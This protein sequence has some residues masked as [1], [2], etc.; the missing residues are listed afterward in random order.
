M[1]NRNLFLAILLMIY[2]SLSAIAKEDNS[3]LVPKDTLFTIDKQAYT[4][5]EFPKEYQKLPLKEQ[6][7]FISRFLYYKIFLKSTKT[8]EKKYSAKIKEALKNKELELKRKGIVLTKLQRI[9]FEKKIAV[10]TIA[11]N[12]VLSKHKKINEKIEKFYTK[13]KDGYKFPKRAEV[14]HIV[15]KDE[16][17][18]KEL[19]KKLKDNNN[20][21]ELFAKLAQEHTLDKK[22]KED[23]GYV[24]NISEKEIG[25]EFFDTVWKTEEGQVVSKALKYKDYYHIIY[26]LKKYK[27]EQRTLDEER[28]SIR[29]FLLKKEIAKWKYYRYNKTKKDT[30]VEFYNIKL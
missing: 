22:T 7:K 23:G 8:E 21:L 14:S 13:N 16:N 3:S 10:D 9:L 6:K 30:K 20:S 5:K 28:D 25:K 29:D 27:A 24:G 1:K 4:Q 26:V 17:R 15:L 19:L 2:T 18:S 11:Y 12:E